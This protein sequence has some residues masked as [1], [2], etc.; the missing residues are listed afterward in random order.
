MREY[1]LLTDNMA[2]LP[3]QWLTEHH[4]ET[5][6]LSYTIDGV[7]YTEDNGL[8]P[9]E[10]YEKIRQGS[11]PVTSQISESLA[12]DTFKSYLAMGKDVLYLAFSSGLSGTYQSAMAAK[13][14]LDDKGHEGKILI[15][16]TLAASLGEGLLVYYAAKLRDEGKSMEEVAAWVEANKLHLAHLFTVN[17]LFHLHRGGRV[18]KASAVFGSMLSIKPVMHMDD[19]GHLTVTGKARGRKKS[20][21]CPVDNM[22]AQIGDYKNEVF[23]ITHS[24]CYEEAK[25]LADQIQKEFGIPSYMINW[26]GPTIGSHTGIGT[27]ALFFLGDRR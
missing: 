9:E 19:E 6:S 26:V 20:L 25:E 16:D 12:Y 13:S 2:D 1:I 7:T 14:V 8:S 15:V 3:K 23:F 4:V 18:S 10:F 21:Q 5:V 24:D 11:M 27:I 22:H 17:D